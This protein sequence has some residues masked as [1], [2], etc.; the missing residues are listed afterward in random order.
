M[1]IK[2]NWLKNTYLIILGILF[3]LIVATPILISD[4]IS[5][6]TE[7][8]TEMIIIFLLLIASILIYSFY[9]NELKKRVEQRDEA[10]K[11]I[12]KINVQIEKIKEAFE[13]IE[14]YPENKSD[15]KYLMNAL[16]E[17]ILG[18]APVDW[19]LLRIIDLNDQ[20]TLTENL[21]TP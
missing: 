19:V 13:T 10:I 7:E 1:H 16:A 20:R 18:I 14:K 8:M 3:V 9:Q 11:E 6:L 17:K 4:G 5:F 2:F 12:G 15:L 21:K